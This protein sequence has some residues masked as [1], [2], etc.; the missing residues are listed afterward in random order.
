MLAVLFLKKP[1]FILW[2]WDQVEIKFATAQQVATFWCLALFWLLLFFS[3]KLVVLK[4]MYS[5]LKS[6]SPI[7]SSFWWFAWL[8]LIM[9]S[10]IGIKQLV[11]SSAVSLVL[12]IFNCIEKIVLETEHFFFNFCRELYFSIL[13]CFRSSSFTKELY[14]KL[15][16]TI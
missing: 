7:Y 11:V 8:S 4:R 10:W 16:R 13:F 3:S 1:S 5:F 6:V 12:K 15:I 9:T 2:S 14:W